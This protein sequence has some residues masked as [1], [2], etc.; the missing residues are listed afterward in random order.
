MDDALAV[1]V[2]KRPQQ[3]PSKHLDSDHGDVHQGYWARVVVVETSRAV[4]HRGERLAV[5]WRHNMQVFVVRPVPA[6]DV[7]LQQLDHV[8]VV[9]NVLQDL[10]LAILEAGVLVDA[11]DR[12]GFIVE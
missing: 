9:A 7:A 6:G 4:D 3:L 10:E 12:H 5:E 8:W 1:E 2:A 11:F